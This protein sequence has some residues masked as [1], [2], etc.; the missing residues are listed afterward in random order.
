MRP[1]GQLPRQSPETY[2][3]RHLVEFQ[4][5]CCMK[6][7]HGVVFP[8]SPQ[9]KNV[10]RGSQ[11]CNRTHII[12][13]G[14]QL[15][16]PVELFDLVRFIAEPVAGHI[17]W[18]FASRRAG[19][20]DFV[21]TWREGDKVGIQ[22]SILEEHHLWRPQPRMSATRRS[23]YSRRRKTPDKWTKREAPDKQ[24]SSRVKHLLKQ[25]F[26]LMSSLLPCSVLPSCFHTKKTRGK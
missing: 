8:L 3:G 16:F 18:S 25:S 26:T 21:S 5:R 14:H 9:F 13:L 6:W 4:M 7:F 2:E 17:L 11:I 20:A 23:L 24:D 22:L 10:Y 12:E 19:N 1:E 15:I